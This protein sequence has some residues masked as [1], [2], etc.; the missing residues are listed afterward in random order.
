MRR[1]P[2]RISIGWQTQNIAIPSPAA[3]K[4]AAG[5]VRFRVMPLSSGWSP[6]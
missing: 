3:A 2:V 5:R 1:Q 4:A 6:F